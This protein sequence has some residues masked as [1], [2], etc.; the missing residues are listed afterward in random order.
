MAIFGERPAV[1]IPP[2]GGGGPPQRAFAGAID[3][4]PFV[5]ANLPLWHPRATSIVGLTSPLATKARK[6]ARS[7][8]QR[9]YERRG[10]LLVGL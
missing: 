4:H 9:A 6:T 7:I 10:D 3:T 1:S 8:G 5:A 2:F